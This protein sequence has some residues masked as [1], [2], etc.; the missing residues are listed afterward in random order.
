MAIVEN[1]EVARAQRDRLA[2]LLVAIGEVR[3]AKHRMEAE[4]QTEA[5]EYLS[6]L[7][8]G[9]AEDQL[10]VLVLNPELERLLGS[11]L[12]VLSD[13]LGEAA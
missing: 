9:G 3:D 10:Q 1:A 5:G 8:L 11:V 13:S 2:E 6:L 12:V 4:G 7:A